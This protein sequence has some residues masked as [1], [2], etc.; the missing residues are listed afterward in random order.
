M[1]GTLGGAA[2]ESTAQREKSKP[3]PV[4]KFDVTALQLRLDEDTIAGAFDTVRLVSC[5]K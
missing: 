4:D 1:T 5:S 3:N 2:V